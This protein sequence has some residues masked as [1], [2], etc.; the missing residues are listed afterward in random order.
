MK[1]A[2][3]YP[4]QDRVAEF[5][6]NKPRVGIF[7]FFGSGKTFMS[8]RWIEQLYLQQ[9]APLPV[10]VL[11][12]KST[13]GQWGEEIEKHCFRSSSLLTGNIESRL[14]ALSTPADFYIVNYDAVRSPRLKKALMQKRFKTV[15]ADESGQ[16]LKNARTARYAAWRKI[17]KD[18]PYRALLTGKVILERPEDV[19]SQ[20]L[21]LDDGESL[22]TSFWKFRY[23]Y[24]SPGPPWRPYEWEL[25]V[26]AG[27]KI[28]TLMRRRCIQIKEEDVEI[29]LPPRRDFTIKLKMSSKSRE[30]YEKLRDDFATELPDG[31]Q[32]ETKWAM[33]RT[34]K[35]HQLCQGFLY[36]DSCDGTKGTWQE[37]DGTKIEWLR[38]NLPLMIQNGPVLVW[39]CFK[40]MQAR[41]AQMLEEEKIAYGSIHSEL[42]D[43]AR[44][45][46]RLDF[47]EGKFDV[48]LLSQQIAAAG[49][50]LQRANQ[51]IFTCTD[52]KAA[53]RENAEKRCRRIGS[54]IHE[55]IT[56]YDLIMDKSV[57]QAVLLA[58]KH[59]TNIAEEILKHL[60]E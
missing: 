53:L 36:N 44:T 21:F 27:E 52:Y 23:T 49:L 15:L 2:S 42:S 5:T 43:S 40:A 34:S 6:E 56:Y 25:K 10:L 48:F 41:I 54:Q 60:R 59:K 1:T 17:L 47:T 26:G 46:V 33:A 8:I 38:E 4:F 12:L 50:N 37:I 32:Y 19:W 22:G 13:V 58:I 24:F 39:S 7:T 35:M 9:R 18:T 3:L 55:H 14:K 57:D 45:Q 29:E 20:M 11:T 28:A 30:L 51:A 16:F 31:A